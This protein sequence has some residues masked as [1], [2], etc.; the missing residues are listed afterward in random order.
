M[1][2]IGIEIEFFIQDTNTKK[3]REPS[4][5]G[6]PCDESG[7][8]G[9]ARTSPH[10]EP[11]TLFSDIIAKLLTY[12]ERIHKKDPFCE[13]ISSS[14]LKPSIKLQKEYYLKYGKEYEAIHSIYNTEDNNYLD[15]YWRAGIHVHFSDSYNRTIGTDKDR[16][17]IE[18]FK[19][20]NIPLIIRKFDNTFKDIIKKN[21]RKLGLYRLKEH[22]FEYRSLPSV[23]ILEP[24]LK[25]SYKEILSTCKTFFSLFS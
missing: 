2:K 5:F 16:E 7:Y 15:K 25:D 8:L 3:I 18:M 1:K 21:K 6:I 17:T 13:M 4:I 14:F 23:L 20:V 11:E 9:E 24:F 22:G 10:T 19:Q 12:Q